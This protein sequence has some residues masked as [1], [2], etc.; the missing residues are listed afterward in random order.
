LGSGFSKQKADDGELHLLPEADPGNIHGSDPK[1]T[2]MTS[3]R[4]DL[5]EG[6][7][8]TTALVKKG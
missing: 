5:V 4:R 8:R 2:G 7:K 3:R 1:P 6:L